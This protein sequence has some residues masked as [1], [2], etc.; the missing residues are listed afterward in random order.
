MTDG[1]PHI[2]FK[3]LF[4][5]GYNPLYVNGAHGG[6]SPRGEIIMNFYMERPAIPR[7]IGHELN[8]NGTIGTEISVEPS[9][10]KN[11]IVRSV[12]NGIIMNYQTAKD[13]HIWLG[14]RLREL[15]AVEQAKAVVKPEGQ[16]VN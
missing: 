12:E 4:A 5:E 16:S 7:S 15:E 9:D 2:V 8:Q 14:E 6:I 3:Y 10:L 1:K 11:S 13:L